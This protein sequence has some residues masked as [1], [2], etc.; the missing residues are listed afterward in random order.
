V[1][2]VSEIDITELDGIETGMPFMER[3]GVIEEGNDRATATKKINT[4]LTIAQWFRS[5]AVD[6]RVTPS[7]MRLDLSLKFNP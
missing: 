6:Y 3:R 2:Q 5:L 4:L 7:A 1:G